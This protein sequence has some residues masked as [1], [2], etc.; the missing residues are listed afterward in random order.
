MT[1]ELTK[2]EYSRLQ[3]HMETSKKQMRSN[4]RKTSPDKEAEIL[5]AV[6]AGVSTHDIQRVYSVCNKTVVNIRKKHGL[7]GA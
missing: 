4:A 5:E 1:L 3:K 2:T 7:W 6:M